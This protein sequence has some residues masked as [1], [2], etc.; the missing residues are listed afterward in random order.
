MTE[1]TT[2]NDIASLLMAQPELEPIEDE[3]TGGTDEVLEPQTEEAPEPA[4][5]GDDVDSDDYEEV[6]DDDAEE[7]PDVYTVKVDGEEVEITLEEA[8]KGY[9]RDSDY[10]KKTMTLAE[11][12]KAAEAKGAEIDATLSELQSFIKREEDTTDWEALRRNDPA[13]YIERKEALN[14]AKESHEAANAKRQE[15][16]NAQRQ[17]FVNQE[18]SKLTEAMGPA[19]EGEQ[20]N[21]DIKVASDYLAKRGFSEQEIGSIVDHRFWM[22]TIDAAKADQFN[23]TKQKVKKEVK[24]APKSVKP[25]Q[26]VPASERKRQ[27]AKERLGSAN[28]QD[29]ISAL[30]EYMKL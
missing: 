18:V 19:W 8:L 30:A 4:I 23:A 29:S 22:M 15:E 20:R 9:Q 21:A 2:V 17:E 24:R 6:E 5:E 10:R 13:E 1:Q 14:K 26:K 7:G 16:L 11:E 28:K 27:Q 12:R 25:G 3:S